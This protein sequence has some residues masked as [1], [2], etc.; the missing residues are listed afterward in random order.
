MLEARREVYVLR[1]RRTLLHRLIE[2]GEAT[3]DDVHDAVN[4]PQE[5]NPV[6]LGVVPGPLAK[7]GIIEWVGF[8]ETRRPEAP[9]RYPSGAWSI[10]S[11]RWLGELPPKL[12]DRARAGLVEAVNRLTV[13]AHL[14]QW[15]TGKRAA[16]PRLTSLS[17]WGQTVAELVRMFGSRPLGGLTH[18]DG[19]AFRSVMLA[20]GLRPTTIHERIGHARAMLEDAVGSGIWR[21][22]LGGTCGSGPGTRLSAVFKCRW[23]IS[24]ASS[25]LAPTHTGG[26]WSPWPASRGCAPRPSRCS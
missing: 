4:L 3:A 11:P 25:R 13:A 1:G 12:H 17:A 9:A 24:S 18:S 5:I 15:L 20:R 10:E 2:V 26:C 22:T 8:T 6:C 14:E 7:G 16:G 23:Q 19:E 21:S